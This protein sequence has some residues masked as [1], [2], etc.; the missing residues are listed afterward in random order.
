[1]LVVVEIFGF[2]YAVHTGISYNDAMVTLWSND[3][4]TVWASIVA[5]WFGTQ[6]FSKK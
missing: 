1:L 3:M 6:A 5:F 4:Q 2:Y